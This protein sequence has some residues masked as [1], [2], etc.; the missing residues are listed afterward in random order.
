MYNECLVN[1]PEKQAQGVHETMGDEYD[2]VVSCPG[3]SDEVICRQPSREGEGE[4]G[5][6]PLQCSEIQRAEG[7]DPEPDE[8]E[9]MDDNTSAHDRM[10][11]SERLSMREVE[12]PYHASKVTTHASMSLW[13]R[14][15]HAVRSNTFDMIVTVLL[16]INVVFMA[17]KMQLDGAVLGYEIGYYDSELLSTDAQRHVYSVFHSMDNLFTVA[18][19]LDVSLRLVAY[20]CEFFKSGMNWLDFLLVVMSLVF[21]VFGGNVVKP[22]Y[23]RLLRF[24]KIARALR[25]VRTTNVLD[26][27]GL[28]VKCLSACATVLFWAFCLLIG[29]QCVAGMMINSLVVGFIEDDAQDATA[30]LAVFKYYGTWSRT[31]LT[32]FEVLFANWAPACRALVENVSECLL[33]RSNS[34]VFFV[35]YRCIIGFAVLNVVGSVFIQ[36]T[37]RI[38]SSDEDHMYLQRQKHMNKYHVLLKK[39]FSQ[40]DASGDGTV[41]IKEFDE[42]LM[43]G[44][45]KLKFWLSQLELDYHDLYGLFELLDDGDGVLSLQE[46]MAAA[47]RL[48]GQA[49]SIDLWRLETKI[50]AFQIAILN[51]VENLLAAPGTL[52]SASRVFAQAG[53]QYQ[54]SSI[55]MRSKHPAKRQPR[56]VP[57]K[58]T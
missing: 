4:N 53:L 24:G 5:Q 25:V 11:A 27:L 32:M 50:E 39:F 8:A 49:K 36:Q 55:D 38:A 18:F 12:H 1:L 17:L 2:L 43:S 56:D 57:A 41:D 48:K 9:G 51:R 19:T 46:F 6:S 44:N 42:L 33:A 10:Y 26:S 28:L 3:K 7:N 29:M 21:E 31:F 35:V 22:L 20:R 45:P 54:R 40:L 37:M 16:S 30:R 47:M 52:S 14:A 23:L 15:Q 58:D 13:E 34:V